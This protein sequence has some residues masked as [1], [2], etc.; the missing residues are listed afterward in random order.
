MAT[1]GLLY[2][3]KAMK[4]LLILL[5]SLSSAHALEFNWLG[6]TNITL[7]TAN[8]AIMF[9]PYITHVSVWQLLTNAKV[10]S[11]VPLVKRWLAKANI[12]KLD[13]IFVNH[14]HFDHI[15]DLATVAKIY[16]APAFGSH[17]MVQFGLGNGMR[18]EE[19]TQLKPKQTV[20]LGDFKITAF[21]GEHTPHVF[22][23]IF[24]DGKIEHP[25][26]LP[27]GNWELK[28][29]DDFIFHV[30]TPKTSVFFHP[31]AWKSS[32][33]KDYK[34]FKADVLFLGIATRKSTEDQ[35]QSI[36]NDV[37][38]KIIIP[39]HYDNF[40]ED[41]SDNPSTLPTTN[42]EEWF[43]SMKKLK[44]KIKLIRPTVAKWINLLETAKDR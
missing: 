37:E 32:H 36:I 11:D 5:S 14:A 38:P 4:F 15:L 21:R 7:K 24:M 43:A 17:S 29:G 31:F 34:K 12:T 20:Q 28:K 22:N 16:K 26:S 41:L 19:L 44:P 18:R 30:K 9:D 3:N 2:H 35:I 25:L 1:D 13:G 27:A 23:T 40:F 39:L 10:Q 6:T 33:H 42:P 8:H